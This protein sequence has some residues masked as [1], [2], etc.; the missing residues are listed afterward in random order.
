MPVQPTFDLTDV[1]API[2]EPPGCG[3]DPRADMS[4]QSPFLQ[5]KD[6]RASAR[7]KERALDVDSDSPDAQEDWSAAG[8][9]GVEILSTTGKDLEV[10]SWTIEALVRIGG[11]RGLYTGC[12]LAAELVAT[13]WD[14]IYPLPDEDGN[15]GRLSPFIALNGGEADGLLIQPLR[16]V[17]LTGGGE[18]FSLWQYEQAL[19]I[20]RITDAGRREARLA[21]GA[22]TM[23]MFE[24]AVR[25]T[26]AHFYQ[27]LV[28]EIA[29][30]VAAVNALSDAFSARV[31]IEAPPAG[32]IRNILQTILEAVQVF[33]RAKLVQD[34]PAPELLPE[35]D[36]DAEPVPGDS[37]HPALTA[38]RAGIASREQA[39]RLLTDA[40]AF[41][42]T[43]EPHSPISY[44]LE[45]IVRRARLPMGALLEELI[46]DE[47]ARRYFYISAGLRP[48]APPAD[49]A[50]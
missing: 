34:L 11:F 36:E 43:N 28:E 32:A 31:G 39:L 14:G 20:S 45:E 12:T 41:F 40:A 35:L 38:T 48:P 24:E 30:A 6:A 46:V 4:I 2:G 27:E 3:S 33:A 26:P 5:M 9:L 21:T 19:D 47:D 22:I 37:P 10:A 23:E 42:R 44:T 13:Y 17:P 15:D 7:R 25:L 1:I 29:A 8:A 50:E 49:M 16:K 18:T